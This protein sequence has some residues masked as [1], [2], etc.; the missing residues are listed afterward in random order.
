MFT[1]LHH[2]AIIGSDYEASRRF[3]VD[4]LGFSVINEQYRVERDDY[5]LDLRQGTVQLE[6]FIRG[7]APLRPSYPEA[8]GLRHLAFAVDDIEGALELLLSK[9]IE[10][11]P[12]RMDP[13]TGKRA[14]FFFDPDKLPL[15]LYEK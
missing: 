10:C 12:L 1:E 8:L 7:D 2:I 6:L 9:G 13:D 4:L 11:E 5:K 14:T 3:Y 15:E